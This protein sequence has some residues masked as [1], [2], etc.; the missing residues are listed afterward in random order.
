MGHAIVQ[1]VIERQPD[2]HNLIDPGLE[3]TGHAEVVHRRGNHQ[4]IVAEQFVDELVAERQIRL[5]RQRSCLGFGVER[6]GHKRFI[7]R[8][9]QHPTDFA[10]GQFRI[11]I[12]GLPRGQ[13]HF[14]Q[15]PRMRPLTSWTG[16]N[17]KNFTHLNLLRSKLERLVVRSLKLAAAPLQMSKNQSG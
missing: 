12:S 16:M 14:R 6:G 8:W 15:T 4:Q 17:S 2:P 5:H 11:W 1:C 10:A 13:K 9:Y 7:D 3:A